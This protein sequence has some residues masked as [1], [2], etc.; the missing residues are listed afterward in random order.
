MGIFTPNKVISP[1]TF[2][3]ILLGE[4]ALFLIIWLASPFKVL[5]RPGEVFTALGE[6]WRGGI[7]QELIVSFGLFMQALALSTVISTCLAYLTV[8]PVFRPL[9]L[10]VSRGRFLSLVGFSVVFTLMFGGDRPVK[11]AMLTLGMSVF[12]LTSLLSI[13]AEIPRSQ[14]DYAR[15][16]RLSEWRVVWEVVVRGTIDKVFDAVRQNAAITWTLLPMVEAL[17]RS[18]GGLGVALDIQRKYFHMDKVFAIQLIV[19][20]VGLFQDYAVG[21]VRQ[22]ICPWADLNKERSDA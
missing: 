5:P 22:I 17:Y 2:R 3:L 15:T 8:I 21:L 19:L 11:L 1:A 12:L 14:Y 16:L 20:C 18:E 7:G 4:A 10:V 13:I 6:L 9:A